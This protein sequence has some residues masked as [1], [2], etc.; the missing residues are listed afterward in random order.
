MLKLKSVPHIFNEEQV[1]AKQARCVVSPGCAQLISFCQ[2]E[3]IKHMKLRSENDRLTYVEGLPLSLP[4]CDVINTLTQEIEKRIAFHI[5]CFNLQHMN[6]IPGYLARWRS[7]LREN[8]QIIGFLFGG[9]SLI[10]LRTSW[11]SVEEELTGRVTNRFSPLA[12]PFSIAQV[13]TRTHY[14]IPVAYTC[15][16]TVQYERVEDIIT[17]IRS[18]GLTN[19]FS[20]TLSQSLPRMFMEKLDRRYRDA[21]EDENGC[22]PLSLD[23]ICFSGFASLL[24]SSHYVQQEKFKTIPRM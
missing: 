21:Y 22:V 6:D 5:S 7:K 18:L 17:D 14:A 16:F 4:Q 12:Q 24:D 13:L 20:N 9:K 8:G 23:I 15:S 2:N 1:K 19:S 3:V 11:Y 10:E